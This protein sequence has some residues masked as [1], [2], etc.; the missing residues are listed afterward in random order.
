[1]DRLILTGLAVLAL[2]SCTASTHKPFHRMSFQELSAYNLSVP[3]LKQVHCTEEVRAGSHIKKTYCSTVEDMIYGLEDSA[4]F[5]G[6][7][8]YASF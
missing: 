8:N 7:I 5:L 3:T 1:M 4:E 6:T 2:A